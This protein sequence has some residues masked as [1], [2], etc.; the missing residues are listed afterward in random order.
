MPRF[1]CVIASK[2]G[3]AFGVPPTCS[4]PKASGAIEVASLGKVMSLCF[5]HDGPVVLQCRGNAS[6]KRTSRL[7]QKGAIGGVPYK[8]VFEEVI[9][10][11]WQ[12]LPKQET[13]FN[14]T[15]ERRLQHH[16]RLIA[17]DTFLLEAAIS[18]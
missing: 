18:G 15:V 6:V 10:V 16:C 14:E 8:S 7:A 1:K 4:K 2:V 9:R 5:R 11:R 12:T 17:G 3:R 13:C